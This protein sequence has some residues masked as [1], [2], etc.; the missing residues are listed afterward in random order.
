MVRV[1]SGENTDWNEARF[2]I[3]FPQTL[4]TTLEKFTMLVRTV[5]F[6]A[7]VGYTCASAAQKP[8]QDWLPISQQEKEIHDVPAPWQQG[9]GAIQLYFSYYKDDNEKFV[10]VYKKIKIL[11]E[12]G[13]KYADIE[14]E[15]QPGRSLK[16]L[17]ARTIHPDGTIVDY[18]GK[19]FDKTIFKAR[20][21]SYTATTFTLPDVTVGSIV[22]YRYVLSLPPHIVDQISSWPIEHELFTLKEDLRFRAF[23]GVVEVPTERK[24]GTPRSQVSFTYVNQLDPAI[25]EK[26]NDNL[27]H[28]QLANVPPFEPE[29]YMPPEDQF[30]PELYFYYGGRETASPDTF[31]DEWARIE[32]GYKEKFIGNFSQVRD[33]AMQAIGNESDPEKKL[34]LLYA[35]AQQI[36]NL[37]FERERTDQERKKENLKPNRNAAEVLA[38]GYGTDSDINYLFVALARAAGF[39]ADLLQVSDRA[40]RSFNKMVLSLAQFK[41]EVATVQLNGKSMLFDPGTLYCPFGL[42][43]WRYTAAQAMK[44][45]SAGA[46]FM[47]MPDPAPSPMRRRAMV[48]L[49]SDGSLHGEISVELNGEEALEHRLDALSTDDAGRS[50]RFEE[51]VQSWLPAGATVKM[52]DAMGWDAPDQPL[53]A[54]FDVFIPSFASAA[55][56]RLL[57]PSLLLT[58][59]HKNMFASDF[60]RY[61]IAFPYSFEESDEVTITLPSG[62]TV[63]VPPYRR[64]A[65]LSYASYL[66]SSEV[67]DNK[68]TTRR[69]LKVDGVNFPP[70]KYGELKEFFTIVQ[71]GD[72]GQCVLHNNS[73]AASTAANQ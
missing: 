52:K 32:S 37:S 58:T 36:R 17:A 62:Y 5:L 44:F 67:A 24:R 19:P 66:V 21:V 65:G 60:R 11:R 7:I 68:L 38:H 16:Q 54:R 34:R 57:V 63:E 49:S 2:D 22:E 18:S 28:L 35:A 20:G 31:W 42:L 56:K 30:K 8:I 73:E 4:P 70:E 53:T 59:L 14:I 6:V 1:G 13:K 29:E 23:Q 15:L 10:S 46:Q 69:S 55:G 64:K 40:E 41:A 47:T 27:M 71:S 3:Y 26:T 25:P 51:E 50:K 9:A 12:S 45:T 61:P 43:R 39:D 48:S 33:R 72:T